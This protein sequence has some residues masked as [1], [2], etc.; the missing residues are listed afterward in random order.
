[1]RKRIDLSNILGIS[2]NNISD[3]FVL[4]FKILEN[5][6]RY[7]SPRRNEIISTIAEAY[8]KHTNSRLKFSNVKEEP[9]K[10]YVTYTKYKKDDE[11]YTVMKKE[12][13]CYIEDILNSNKKE[14]I[15]QKTDDGNDKLKIEDN[16]KDKKLGDNL[17]QMD[18]KNNYDLH[19]VSDKNPFSTALIGGAIATGAGVTAAGGSIVACL[20]FDSIFLMSTAGEVFTAGF[21]LLG[22]VAF[23]GI[24]L[25][26]AVPSLLG[27]GAY[28]LYR[29]NK[30]NKRKE[31]FKDFDEP[32]MKPE[33]EVY[34]HAIN[35]IDNY[36]NKY[37]SNSD[38]ET[39]YRITSIQNYIN[40]IID[41]YINIDDN[42]F[43]SSL[44]LIK[45]D[46]SQDKI[47][48]LIKKMNYEVT[49]I[50][51]N[52][53]KIRAEL[54]RT[55]TSSV[56]TDI[57]KIFDEGI[58][59]FK[60]FIMNFGPLRIDEE[61]EKII[62]E[63][64]EKL[65]Q[66]IKWILE[67]KMQNSF[68][69]FD[70]K[71][72][73][74]S[75][76]AY[77]NQ[78]YEE[79]RKYENDFDQKIFISNCNDF[80]IEPISDKSK[81]YGVLSLYIRFAKIVQ[82]IAAKNKDLHFNKN[83][84]K[85]QNMMQESTINQTFNPNNILGNSSEKEHEETPI[86]NK[87]NKSNINNNI[88]ECFDMPPSLPVNS[89]NMMMPN[90]NQG[91]MMPNA[92]QGDMIPNMIQGNMMPNVIQGNMMPNMIQGNMMPNANQ[93]NM[94]PNMIQ[95]NMMPN[96]I[97]GN[98]MPNMI[99]GNIMPNAINPLINSYNNIFPVINQA[100]LSN[101]YPNIN[102]INNFNNNNNS[103]I[104]KNDENFTLT[105]III[106]QNVENIKLD[107]QAKSSST[108]KNTINNFAI[109]VG[110]N[111]KYIKKYLIDDK[112]LLDPSSEETLQEK[113]INEQTKIMAYNE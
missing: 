105:F 53:A 19:T 103:Q 65:I 22:G 84:E 72:F 8:F 98:M 69:N 88:N 83:K 87:I 47:E 80:L 63:N 111:I 6:Y 113:G 109:K 60:E 44:E 99:Q 10:N 110:N 25:I 16:D 104:F 79:K 24:G 89:Q 46:N 3:E 91:N 95:G 26:V 96:V 78:K 90:A 17:I 67:N 66:E 31:F 54:M 77:L 51:K 7:S 49:I 43:N 9:L 2:I 5:D 92:N 97:Q 108:I 58:P 1:M 52:I 21:T 61:N 45:N 64:I 106:G 36:F 102:P 40:S 33:K 20:V 14:K 56:N 15:E 82:D 57:K 107:V 23:T 35:K 50:L 73:I 42:R 28:K 27:F 112:I 18:E 41:I 74:K 30:E 29:M 32:K 38:N 68:K 75:F 59:Y 13:N 48:E 55:L 93:G 81:N 100:P 12:D 39:N 86:N 11:S 34:L 62:K 76:D 4:H 70:S 94:M 37:I 71:V 85:L 101:S